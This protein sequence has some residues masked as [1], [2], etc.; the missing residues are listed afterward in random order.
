MLEFIQTSYFILLYVIILVV[1]IAT[2]HRYFDTVLKFFPIYIAYTIFTELLGYF[3]ITY[4]D[5]SF[6]E[7]PKYAWYNVIIFNIHSVLVF[8]YF[9]WV[10]FKIVKR[11]IYKKV[12]LYFGFTVLLSY[13]LNCFIED[14][15]Y[16]GL[17][18]ADTLASLFYIVVA[19]MY[20]SGRN[21]RFERHNFMFWIT[22]GLLIFHLIFPFLNLTGFLKPK[23]WVEYHFRDILKLTIVAS[24]T[25]YLIGLLLGRRRAFR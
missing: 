5:I 25:M 4:E 23:I 6:F 9:F 16:S 1:A 19:L 12:I 8:G 10:Y 2:Y 7:D 14:P 13:V 11:K 21:W 22:L 24:Y 20:F 3:I 17:Y 18:Q 15:F